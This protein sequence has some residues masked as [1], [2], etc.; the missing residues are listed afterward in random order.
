MNR[1]NLSVRVPA[2]VERED[3]VLAGLTARQLTIVAGTGVALWLLLMATRHVVPPLLIAAG[4]IPVMASA[5]A[6]ALVRRDGVSLDRLFVAA[7]RQHLRPRRRVPG[8][9]AATPSFLLPYAGRAPAP[10]GLPVT[11]VS[12][13]GVIALGDEGCAAV[14]ACSTV[15]FA[16][17][18]YGEQEAMVA[19]FARCLHGLTAPVQVL[20]RAERIDL[21]PMADGL[22]QAAPTLPDPAL[23]VSAREHAAFLAELATRSELLRRQVLV[24]VRDAPGERADLES[25]QVLRMGEQLAAALTATGVSAHVLDGPAAMS[26]LAASCDPNNPAPVPASTGDIVTGGTR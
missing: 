8:D 10:L 4:S 18:T 24:V 5:V 19:G 12:P 3:R 11:A 25:T 22:H 6:F 14:V 13:D 23:E 20:I 2:D 21:T 15:S 26:V 17:A 1:E 16:L 7:V 9:V